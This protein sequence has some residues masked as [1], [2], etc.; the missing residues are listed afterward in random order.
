LWETLIYVFSFM[1]IAVNM[2]LLVGPSDQLVTWVGGGVFPFLI[3]V[4]L[5]VRER[6]CA[7]TWTDG[8]PV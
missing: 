8:C 5:E 1:C 2:A 7:C 3:A 6:H 4:G